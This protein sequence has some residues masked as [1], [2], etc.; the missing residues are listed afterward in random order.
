VPQLGLVTPLVHQWNLTL[1]QEF[2]GIEFVARYL[3]NKGQDLLRAIDYNQVLYNANGFLDDFKR[4]QSNAAL[5][6]AA[7]KG[8]IGAYNPAIP[9]SQPLT[10]FPLLANGGNISSAGSTYNSVYLR[11][12][13]IGEM[14][15]QYM[16]NGQ[17]GSVNFYTNPNVQGANTVTNGGS[18]IFHALQLEATKRLHKGIQ[19]HFSYDFGKGLSNTAG[20]GQTNFEPLLDNASPSLEWA[21]TPFDIRHILKANYYIELPFGAGR[22]WSSGHILNQVIGGWALAGIWNYQSGSPYSILSS[23]GTLNRDARS[24]TT[25]TACL[26]G[27]TAAQ[28]SS[29]TSGIWKSSNGTVY[30]LSPSLINPVD[31]RGAAQPGSA[32]FQGQVFFNPGPG[33]VGTT[34]R[35]MFSGPWL[36]SWDI[37]FKKSFVFHERHSLDLHFDFFNWTN[38]PAFRIYPSTAGDSGN[39]TNNNIN[40]TTFG[41]VDSLQY[42]PRVIQIGAYYRF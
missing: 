14:A 35:R 21:R 1:Q 4:A 38:H 33:T 12:G 2:K 32:P 27:T 37:S 39:V 30:F 13:N 31:G 9:G 17:N 20:D 41:Q 11:Q 5:S 3:G 16:V 42:S 36:W 29:L 34:Q 18:S 7:G 26:Q 6:E 19:F 24:A 22:R 40:N 10:V 8:F 15:N 25:N 23:L 28:L